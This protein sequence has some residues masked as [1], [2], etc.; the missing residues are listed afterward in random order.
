MLTVAGIGILTIGS[1][2]VS[3]LVAYYYWDVD[4]KSE[5]FDKKCREELAEDKEFRGLS[6]SPYHNIVVTSDS[7]TSKARASVLKLR[8]QLSEKPDKIIQV[9]EHSHDERQKKIILEHCQN[10]PG[11]LIIDKELVSCIRNFF[12]YRLSLK[13]DD[14]DDEISY[15][16]KKEFEEHEHSNRVVNLSKHDTYRSIEISAIQARDKNA[17]DDVFLPLLDCA[18]RFIIRPI[19]EPDKKIQEI[20]KCKEFMMFSFWRL[21][22]GDMRG[23]KMDE[24]VENESVIN[25]LR[26]DLRENDHV[27]YWVLTEEECDES[28]FGQMKNL[29]FKLAKALNDYW[30][31]DNYSELH[32]PS[33]SIPAMEYTPM[34]FILFKKELGEFQGGP[35]HARIKGDPKY[36]RK[37][38]HQ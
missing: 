34:S 37:E 30:G 8:G 9:D 21:H 6:Q 3:F 33:D 2:I 12:A 5:S 4:R 36:R 28:E 38:E 11:K 14:V 20:D 25:K 23:I 27:G 22:M 35:K 10:I 17:L 16:F 32:P 7:K 24:S 31:D 26:A 18:E 13:M 19:G 29:G 1:L 15:Y